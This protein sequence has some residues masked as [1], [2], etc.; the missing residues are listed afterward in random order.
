MGGID[1]EIGRRIRALRLTRG[2]TMEQVAAQLG[3]SQQ[4]IQ[5][6]ETGSNRVSA[7]RLFAL[8]QFLDVPVSA[9]FEGMQLRTEQP[10]RD[11]API[12]SRGYTLGHEFDRL[13]ESQKQAVLSLVRSMAGKPET[14]GQ[15]DGS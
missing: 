4:Q 6:Y 9:F 11:V 15:Q 8:A 5:K 10:A 2:L 13:S 3:I 14:S 12:D 7:S 1:A